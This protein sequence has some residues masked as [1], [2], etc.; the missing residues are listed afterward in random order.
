MRIGW[1]PNPRGSK[2][3]SPGRLPSSHGGGE[4]PGNQSGLS[5]PSGSHTA[6]TPPFVAPARWPAILATAAFCDGSVGAR[7]AA[8]TLSSEEHKNDIFATHGIELRCFNGT[9]QKMRENEGE[10]EEED[11]EIDGRC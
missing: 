7:N 6:D 4:L 5:G 11:D 1:L 9:T 10:K 3:K 2:P 8:R